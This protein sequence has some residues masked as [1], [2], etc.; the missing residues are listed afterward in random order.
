MRHPKGLGLAYIPPMPANVLR[1]DNH[2]DWNPRWFEK[3]DASGDNYFY[4]QPRKVVHIDDDAIAA[5]T[6]LYRELLPAGGVIL[7]LMSAWRSH[8][9]SDVTYARVT[10]LGM[11]ADEMADNAQLTDFVVHNLNTEPGLPFEAGTFDAA[12]CT[13]SVQYLQRPVEVLRELGRVLK[14]DAPMIFTFSNRCF[15]SKAINLWQMT[16]DEEHMQVVSLY[17]EAAGNWRDIT[18]QD[19]SAECAETGGCDPLFA[20]WAFNQK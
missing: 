20:V 5:A 4:Q 8:L 17:F 11:N 16:H 15:P 10:G 7:D 19:R 6:E 18:M 14:P 9:P 1:A 12:C 3:S 2:A 13:V